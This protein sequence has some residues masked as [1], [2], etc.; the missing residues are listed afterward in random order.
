MGE[1]H[2][3]QVRACLEGVLQATD[4]HPAATA[5]RSITSDGSLVVAGECFFSA[6]A[7]DLSTLAE[8][9]GVRPISR[10]AD[11]VADFWPD[12]ETAD[13]FIATLREWRREG[14]HA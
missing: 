9:Q 13:E 6:P 2:L 7:V 1:D 4:G 14:G 5:R 3:D 12:G 10:L 8:Q 11:L